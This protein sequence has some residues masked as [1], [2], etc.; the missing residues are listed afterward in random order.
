V[1]IFNAAPRREDLLAQ[2]FTDWATT[3]LVKED[4]WT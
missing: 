3:A 1:L 4:I 2:R